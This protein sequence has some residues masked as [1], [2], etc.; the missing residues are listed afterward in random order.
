[1][2]QSPKSALIRLAPKIAKP[3]KKPPL[4]TEGALGSLYTSSVFRALRLPSYFAG[5]KR[6]SLGFPP[7]FK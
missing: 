5:W 7:A 3:Q 2:V 6:A 1:M 4:L